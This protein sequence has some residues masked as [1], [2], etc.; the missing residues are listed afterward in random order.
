MSDLFCHKCGTNLL[1]GAK[2]CSSCGTPVEVEHQNEQDTNKSQDTKQNETS[3]SVTV[4][5]ENTT[6]S[7][8][9][10]N[11]SCRNCLIAFII[12]AVLLVAISGGCVSVS[13]RV[14]NTYSTRYW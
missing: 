1:E 8:V 14:F 2:F 11:K 9:T 3:W 4:D 13:R 10:T 5:K 6:Q 7:T 12:L